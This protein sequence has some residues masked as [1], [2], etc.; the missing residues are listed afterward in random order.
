[1]KPIIT[2][3]LLLFLSLSGICQSQKITIF[4]QVNPGG[5]MDYNDL[6]RIL[7]DSIK[8]AV[9]I[10]PNKEHKIRLAEDALI[11]ME[12]NGWKALNAFPNNGMTTYFL[13][14]EIYLDEAARKLFI[15]KLENVSKK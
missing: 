3:S 6:A 9:M 4:C 14:R 12:L 15:E 1:M 5:Y 2:L 11:W 7:P 10:W 8:T 13:S